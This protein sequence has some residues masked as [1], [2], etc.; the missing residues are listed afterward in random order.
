MNE[1][2][3]QQIHQSYLQYEKNVPRGVQVVRVYDQGKE[4]R[5]MCFMWD[6]VEN[7]ETPLSITIGEL[8]ELHEMSTKDRERNE[9]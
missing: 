2:T 7:Q 5:L 6:E 1:F 8:L 3:L 9:V 4:K